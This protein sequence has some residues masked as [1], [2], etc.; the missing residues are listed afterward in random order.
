MNIAL[1]ARVSTN[2]QTTENQLI[3]LRNHALMRNW[4]IVEEYIDQGFS[5]ANTKRPALDQLIKDSW[6]G[7]FEAILVWRFDRFARSVKH[8]ITALEEFR[9]LKI[10]FI[11]LQE[12]FDT[13]SPIGQAMFVIIGAMAELER[14]ILRE[15]VKAGQA[16]ARAEGKRIGRT[17]RSYDKEEIQKLRTEGLSIRKISRKVGIPKTTIAKFLKREIHDEKKD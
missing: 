15:R 2:D 4:K 13:S 7:K 10:N 6:A 16:R 3:A 17:P 1:Y 5:G 8:L 9:S 14:N 11:S 12:Q